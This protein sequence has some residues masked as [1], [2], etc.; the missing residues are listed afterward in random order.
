MHEREPIEYSEPRDDDLVTAREVRRMFGGVSDMTIWRWMHSE[1]VQFPRPI[2]ISGKNYWALGDLR[3][4]R[5]RCAK[6]AG[7]SHPKVHETA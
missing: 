3:R 1:N 4:F 2:P 6:Q 7:Q 5:E